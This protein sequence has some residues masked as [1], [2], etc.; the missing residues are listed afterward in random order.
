MRRKKSPA[1]LA[2]IIHTGL[3]PIHTA[4]SSKKRKAHTATDQ[5]KT[6]LEEV[7]NQILTI[8]V[9]LGL[10]DASAHD[11]MGIRAEETVE[12]IRNAITKGQ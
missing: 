1:K 12:A 10:Y 4:T 8:K 3:G 2:D 11:S 5:L 9:G 7:E 6:R